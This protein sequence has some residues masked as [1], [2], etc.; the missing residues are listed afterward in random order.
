MVSVVLNQRLSNVLVCFYICLLLFYGTHSK[1]A[2]M[3][4][5]SVADLPANVNGDP[6]VS[7]RQVTTKEILDSL[8]Y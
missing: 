1:L 2:L 8:S 6:L 4:P 7:L 3:H 5:C